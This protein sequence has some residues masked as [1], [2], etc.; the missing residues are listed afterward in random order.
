MFE[1]QFNWTNGAID[2]Q[3]LP[4]VIK[5]LDW[6]TLKVHPTIMGLTTKS[7]DKS[8]SMICW[9]YIVEELEQETSTFANISTELAQKARQYTK[10]VEVTP[11]Y[12]KFAQIF[13]EEAL[14][15]FPPRWPQYDAIKLKKDAPA[16]LNCKVYPTRTKKKVALWEWLDD[17]LKKGY[18]TVS[19]SPYAS[20]FFFIKEKD[21]KLCPVQDYCCLNMYTI[22]NTY[23]LLDY[24]WFQY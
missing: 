8:L 14:Q 2:T 1:P 4:I 6:R 16:M 11:Y 7:E 22:R 17:Q 18:I 13:S 20:P 5:S 12:Q 3:Y 23:P 24:S 19:N 15:Q 21:G 9:A 10:K